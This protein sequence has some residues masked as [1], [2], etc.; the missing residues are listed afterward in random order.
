MSISKLNRTFCR[1]TALLVL[2]ALIIAGMWPQVLAKAA[3]EPVGPQPNSLD[4]PLNSLRDL[5]QAF[6]DIAARVKPAVVT[7]STER[8]FHQRIYPFGNPFAGDPF[9]NFFFN[10]RQH[11]REPQEREYRQQGLGSG[12]V[13]SHDGYILT[14]NHVIKDADS[15][16]VRTYDGNRYSA[17]VVGADPHT[18]IAVLKIEAEK[19]PYLEFGNSDDLQVGEIVL[20]IGSPMSEN[21]AYTVT[22]GIVSAKGRSNVGLADYEDFI[23]TD[24]AINPGNSGGPLVNLDGELVGLNTAIV[25]RSGGFQGIGFAVPSRMAESVMNSLIDNG[26]VVR[27]WMGVYIQEVNDQIASAFGLDEVRGALI[28]EVLE[29][30]PAEDAGLEA[31]DI[32][33][34]LDGRPIRDA[35]ELRN[36]VASSRPGA[37]VELT[38]LRDG[39]TKTVKMELGELPDELA[40]TTPQGD[41]TEEILGFTVQT[42]DRSLAERLGISPRLSGVVVTEIDPQSNAARSGVQQGDLITSVNRHPVTNVREFKEQ[43]KSIR[44][45]STVLLKV[46][47]DGRGL[48][49]AF[50]L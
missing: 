26:R 34:A 23:Q 13:V 38:I 4:R 5:N 44:S 41:D 12:V 28:S 39:K 19:L 22:Q 32:V 21:L 48:Y 33:I 46:V 25:S 11:P 24:A 3:V 7:V 30:S 50:D 10:P 43:I 15:I 40:E 17:K 29:D 16:Y 6:I 49:L 8:I 42:L 14:N 1:R 36:S 9:F 45:G 37:R 2:L 27:G 20:A 35:A 47:R 18:D 31:G